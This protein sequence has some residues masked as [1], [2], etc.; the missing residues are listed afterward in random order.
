[1]ISDR[2]SAE[3]EGRQI[4]ESK[5]VRPFP[6][7]SGEVKN[8]GAAGQAAHFRPSNDDVKFIAMSEK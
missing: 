8:L 7:H 6:Q 4:E 2:S 5:L 3:F 1:M